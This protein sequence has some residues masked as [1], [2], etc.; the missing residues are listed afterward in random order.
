MS[1][2]NEY[3]IKINKNRS[4]NIWFLEC[5]SVDALAKAYY[6]SCCLN[7]NINDSIYIPAL[8]NATS[9]NIKET[10][11]FLGKGFQT[12]TLEESVKVGERLNCKLENNLLDISL[13]ENEIVDYLIK[14][15]QSC[16]PD[17]LIYMDGWADDSIRDKLDGKPVILS[18]TRHGLEQALKF[19]MLTGRPVIFVEDYSFDKN[20]FRLLQAAK[21]IT[22]C[23]SDELTVENIEE[24]FDKK[25]KVNNSVSIGFLYPYGNINREYVIVKSFVFSKC[26]M[27]SDLPF[28]FFY[29]LEKANYYIDTGRSR[30]IIGKGNGSQSAEALCK[31]AEF[32]F[33]TPH[34]NGIDM[35]LGTGILCSKKGNR[36]ISFR[37]KKS[38]ALFFE[39]ICSRKRSGNELVGVS[40]I[41]S[42]IV[43]LYT[44]W[45]VVLKG[46]MYDE[47][48]SLAYQFA[49]SP[50]TSVL[51]TTYSMS[52][53]DRNSG[54]FIASL[55]CSGKEIGEAIAD[56]NKLHYRKYKDTV[57][58][59]VLFGDP[60][61]KNNNSIPLDLNLVSDRNELLK[62]FFQKSGINSEL[63]SNCE[64]SVRD[65]SVID[66]NE[67]F[68]S[69]MNYINCVING[70][71]YL[72]I[73]RIEDSLKEFSAKYDDLWMFALLYRNRLFQ[74]DEFAF[75][76]CEMNKRYL[77]FLREYQEGWFKFYKSMVNSLGGYIRFQVDRYFS[78]SKEDVFD[79]KF[80]CPYCNATVRMEI[81]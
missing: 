57:N 6:I 56:F 24:I 38:N 43:F 65:L 29:P 36:R 23:V 45:G 3:D 37:D 15:Y 53:L 16:Y 17:Q 13:K 76:H 62:E 14:A 30:F 35:S 72:K 2:S 80:K 44:C 70:S 81:K 71:K 40:E 54:T 64:D 60:E 79:K 52:L 25:N 78:L 4:I 5:D 27:P 77:Y 12:T 66:I 33:A 55:Y 8:S 42:I 34:S 48:I 73:K 46:G 69:N 74:K 28:N 61:F 21:S 1:N 10:L 50:Y 41:K 22:V 63:I 51:I 58:V 19:G 18:I 32:L 7:K 68:F 26:E 47:K 20:I 39:D 75:E 59:I 31:P 9:E 49:Q 11:K 67:K